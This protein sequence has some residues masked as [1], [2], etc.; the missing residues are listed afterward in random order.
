M[1]NDQ[2]EIK[3]TEKSEITFFPKSEWIMRVSENGIEFNTEEYPVDKITSGIIDILCEQFWDK[4]KEYYE[5]RLADKK[6]EN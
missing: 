6:N 4:V 2:T 5:K 1:T 3:K